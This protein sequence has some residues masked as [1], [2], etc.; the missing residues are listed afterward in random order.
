[1]FLNELY[2]IGGLNSIRGFME[3]SIYASTYSIAS[4][5]YRFVFERNSALFTFFDA[6]WYEKKFEDYYYDYP[7]G[8][9]FGLFFK[10]KAGIFTISYAMGQQK[11]ENLNIKNAKIHFGFI[12]KF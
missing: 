4:F 5:E 10:T 2:R 3:S 7:M 1:M 6:A 8:F 9:G 12:N 11:N